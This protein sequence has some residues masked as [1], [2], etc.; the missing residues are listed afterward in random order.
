[1]ATSNSSKPRKHLTLKE[2]VKV[3]QLSQKSH[4]LSL[5]ELEYRIFSKKSSH[6]VSQKFRLTREFR[7]VFPPMGKADETLELSDEYLES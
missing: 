2:K 3:I 6:L 5:R 1:M 4:K 7:V